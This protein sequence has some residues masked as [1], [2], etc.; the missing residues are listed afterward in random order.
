MI[1]KILRSGDPKLRETSKPVTKIDSKIL[2]LV[3][4]LKE[5]LAVQKDPEGV[6]LAAPQIGKNLRVFA[7]NYKDFKKVFINPK[8]LEAHASPAAKDKPPTAKSD[9]L[10]G[11]LSLPN[12]YGSLKRNQKLKVK[13]QIPE[14][15]N[16]QWSIIN[17]VEEFKGFYA[18][19][20]LHEIDH[21]NGVLFIDRLLENK[22]PLYKLSGDK[23]EE[24]DL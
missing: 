23:W 12:Y 22:K 18:Q 9:I 15:I 2:K 13:Y 5:T 17:K 14:K 24:V 21:L 19:I 4:D 20:I 8:I 1:R 11:C 16:G 3:Q 10:E 6:G 7:V